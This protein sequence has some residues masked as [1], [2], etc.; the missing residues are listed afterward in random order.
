MKKNL[1]LTKIYES[2]D[3]INIYE[4]IRKST[5]F[6]SETKDLLCQEINMQN[7]E[8][9]LFNLNTI[10]IFINKLYS[11]AYLNLYLN[12]KNEKSK[13]LIN[14]TNLINNSFKLIESELGKIT[15]LD[16]IES[17]SKKSI[18]IAEH[19]FYLNN[20]VAS[21][22]V[23]NIDYNSNLEYEYNEKASKK[24][25]LNSTAYSINKSV[26]D[27]MFDSSLNNLSFEYL[28]KREKF[29]HENSQFF[30]DILNQIKKESICLSS[31]LGYDSPLKM[32]F[33]N[34]GFNYKSI[35]VLMNSIEKNKGI[36]EKFINT[37]H[38]I[39]YEKKYS[40]N[41]I[42]SIILNSFL[43]FHPT[44]FNFSK[45]MFDNNFIDFDYSENK[46]NG[47]THLKILSLKES[48]IVG[49]P[50]ESIKGVF[51]MAHEI[52]H[53]Y[54]CNFIINSKTALNCEVPNSTC[55]IISIFCELLVF[56]YLLTTVSDI[57]EKKYILYYF[58]NYFMQAILDVYSRFT[59]ENKVFDLIKNKSNLNFETLNNIMSESQQN[60]YSNYK[61]IDKFLWIYKPH[62]Y[63]ISTP[64]YNYPYAFGLLYSISIFLQYKNGESD[65]YKNFVQFCTNSG[66]MPI[67]SLSKYFEANLLNASCYTDSY[68]YIKK[69]I[70]LYFS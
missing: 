25:R 2:F 43:K 11:Y 4:D 58:I 63:S 5:S 29:F 8:K 48:R 3:D 44:L 6:I 28:K 27:L 55:E 18:Y 57:N 32:S 64:Y 1:D 52:G 30:S 20:L 41:E 51:Q 68:N 37:D 70:D 22:P 65:F 19:K 42:K 10:S 24:I 53:A 7:L 9:I 67:N 49:Q 15:S 14:K 47:T 35:T 56:D 62:F 33:S 34:S 23:F 39:N 17:Y 26:Y 45:K 46:F 12:T 13:N 38:N 69:I 66:C 36:F 59:F 54:Q 61:Y 40:K 50:S 16:I 21:N 31:N 60:A